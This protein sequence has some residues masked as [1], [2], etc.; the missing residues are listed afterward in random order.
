M[1]KYTFHFNDHVVVFKPRGCSR[2]L[3]YS[4]S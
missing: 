4:N 1:Y 3:R 2:D